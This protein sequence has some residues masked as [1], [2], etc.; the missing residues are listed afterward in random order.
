MYVVKVKICV[1]IVVDLDFPVPKCLAYVPVVLY[2]KWYSA[3][4]ENDVS[5]YHRCLQLSPASYLFLKK[6]GPSK[7][8]P[9]NLL[10]LPSCTHLGSLSTR[11]C[12]CGQL[13]FS[14]PPKLVHSDRKW[15]FCGQFQPSLPKFGLAV[16]LPLVIGVLLG[17]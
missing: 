9:I 2:G 15:E 5:I 7:P 13:L 4:S 1:K 8:L 11:I 3:V 6:I 17:F 10:F 12:F 14:T 16:P